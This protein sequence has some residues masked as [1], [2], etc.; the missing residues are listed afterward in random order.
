M[1]GAAALAAL[2]L[3]CL[4]A[5]AAEVLGTFDTQL[6]KVRAVS[7]A[8]GLRYP[9]GLAFLPNGEFL[10]TE[11]DGRL[12][13]ISADGSERTAI[14]G[15]PAVQAI[16]Q[17]GLLDVA[18]DPDFAQTQRIFFTY[19]GGGARGGA[20]T[21]LASAR[22][23]SDRL[24]DVQVLF[25]GE[26]DYGGG[27]HFGSRIAFLPDGTLAFTIGDRGE[28]NPS[29]D[30]T[31]HAGS[32]IRLNRDGSV[33]QD[34]PFLGQRDARP[35]IYSY[36]HRNPQG[37]ILYPPTG[38]LWLHEHG[39]RGGD[40]VNI[41]E[42]GANY[43]WPLVSHGVNYSGTP[44]GTGRDSAPGLTAPLYTWV[45]SIAPSGMAYYD[46]GA[47]PKWRGN[48]LVGALKF[49]LIARLTVRDGEITGEERLFE[50]AF[51]RIR[52]VRSGPDGL[53]YLLTDDLNGRLIRL[54]PAD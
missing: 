9:W 32:V 48:I 41:V 50:A 33:P 16:G 8:D 52:D 26:P 31:S 5:R 49:Q 21:N 15:V 39:P 11:Q 51:G 20:N 2:L 1:R 22:L 6:H 35:E 46:G 18:A 14:A 4:P 12:F 10:V 27:R 44:V 29:Q 17:G 34:N 54:E 47:F 30:L 42:P 53:I 7:L 13:R 37:M 36:G 28:K 3:L 40:E 24:T 45:P 43:G 38:R 23:E 19:S 25:D